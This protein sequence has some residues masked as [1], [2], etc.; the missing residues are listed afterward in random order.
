MAGANPDLEKLAEQDYKYGFVTDIKEDRADPGLTEDV[1]RL[2]SKKKNEPQW[3]LDY[4]LKAFK[5]FREMLEEDGRC[6]R[7]GEGLLPEDRLRRNRVLLRTQGHEEAREPRRGRPGAARDLREARH[8][9]REQKRWPVVAVDAVFDSVSVATTFKAELAKQG[10]IFCSFSEAVRTTPISFRSISA[11]SCRTPTTS[12]HAELRGLQ[13][14]LLRLHPEGRPLPDGALDLFPHQRS[15]HRTV[16]AHPDHR[17]RRRLRQL[18]G[19][20]H[21][22]DAR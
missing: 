5:R 11:R 10:I 1:V 6:P 19:R 9:A 12:S 7:M 17:R 8:S 2:I 18:P 15:E 4:R 22:A 13:R 21:R 20:L 16:R 3:L 14:R